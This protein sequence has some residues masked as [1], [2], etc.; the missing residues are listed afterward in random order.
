M[1]NHTC[2][3]CLDECGD[4][5]ANTVKLACNHMFH[6][7]CLVDCLAFEF[8][9]FS[10]K[11]LESKLCTLYVARGFGIECP[12]CRQ[13]T[14]FKRLHT[15]YTAW[16]DAYIQIKFVFIEDT[17]KFT[18]IAT[19]QESQ[20]SQSIDFCGSFQDRHYRSDD[21][22]ISIVTGYMDSKCVNN[23]SSSLINNSIIQCSFY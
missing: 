8:D 10:H 9:R 5:N 13:T 2:T 19:A 16:G 6:T 11:N 12:N 15:T 23:G 14:V 18:L 1:C 7:S 21:C 20:Y 3:I 17:G 4:D 22:K